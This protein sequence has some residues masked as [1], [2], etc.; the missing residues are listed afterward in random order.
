MIHYLSAFLCKNYTLPKRV[1]SSMIQYLL[2][3]GGREGEMSVAWQGLLLTV[4]KQYGQCLDEMQKS[5][6][7]DLC[8]LKHHKLM[9]PEILK[10]F[11]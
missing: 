7:V 1:L 4:G 5:A 3:F 8:K 2:S 6:I 10:H 9:T 11:A